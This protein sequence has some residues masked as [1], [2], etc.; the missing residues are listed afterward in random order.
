[1]TAMFGN[2]LF[3]LEAD[4]KLSVF[5]DQ[6][7]FGFGW[8]F[9]VRNFS[10]HHRYQLQWKKGKKKREREEENVIEIGAITEI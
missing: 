5:D 3:H 10:W 2:S 4:N 9:F 1:M 8:K 7:Q 6:E